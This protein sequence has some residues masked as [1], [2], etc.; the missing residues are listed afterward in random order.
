MGKKILFSPIGGTDPIKYFRD[1]SMLHICRW[2]KPDIVYLYLSHEMLEKHN[3]D[4]RYRLSIKKL[5]ENIGHEFTIKIIE[6]PDLINVQQYDVF[7]MDFRQEIQ[8]IEDS[9]DKDDELILNMASGTPAMKSALLVLATLA[10]YR[11]KAI[12]VSTPLKTINEQSDDRKE[13]DADMYSELNEDNNP[14][15]ENRCVEVQCINL[16]TLLKKDMIKKHIRAYD[17]TAALT[18]AEEIKYDL[19]EEAYNLLKIANARAKLK[20]NEISKLMAGKKYDIFPITEGDKQKIYEYALVLQI[21]IFK[22]EYADF[23]RGITPI[24]VDLLEK[25]CEKQC[26]IHI[27][28]LCNIRKNGALEWD[29]DALSSAGLLNSLNEEYGSNGFR[30][31]IVYSNHIASIIRRNCN[32]SDLKIKVDEMASVGGIEPVARNVAAH[33]IVAVTDDWF[34]KKTGK[35]AKQIFELIKY[36]VVKAGINVTKE[37]WDV[38]D[39]MNELIE[40]KLYL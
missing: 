1:G 22:E 27:N 2:Y 18:V 36:L 13:Y 15:A 9:M 11:F 7:Y 37:A 26:G 39:K 38:Y 31:G 14:N 32:D 28:R 25:I 30:G 12:Q 19:T 20:F 29:M 33:E 8:K 3:N 34:V 6:R 35:N 23:I 10:E 16:I 17:Y 24:I 4:D 21:K 5:G 40:E